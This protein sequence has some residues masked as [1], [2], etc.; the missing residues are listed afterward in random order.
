MIK[1]EPVQVE[2]PGV[3]NEWM[4]THVHVHA[5]TQARGLTAFGANNLP[6]SYP[7]HP[8]PKASGFFLAIFV[9]KLT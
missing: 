9:A 3:L 8:A 4:Q 1:S 6:E 7:N 5:R 2:T